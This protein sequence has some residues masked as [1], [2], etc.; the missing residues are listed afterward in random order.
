M[1]LQTRTKGCAIRLLG[2]WIGV[3]PPTLALMFVEQEMIEMFADFVENVFAAAE[4]Q[5]V[6]EVVL[7][8]VQKVEPLADS[9]RDALL[10]LE[11]TDFAQLATEAIDTHGVGSD[12]AD[13]AVVRLA[14]MIQGLRP[15]ET[16][17]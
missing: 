17:G 15:D 16:P 1:S 2:H 8:L 5:A 7:S 10:S 9:Y 12:R 13:V 14:E 3:M 4:F 6:P 11:Q